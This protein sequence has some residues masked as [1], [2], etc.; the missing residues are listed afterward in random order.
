V[1][2]LIGNKTVNENVNLS[3][4]VSGADADG[5]ALTYSAT[6]LPSGATLNITS[7]VFSWSPSYSQSGSYSVVFTVS[8]GN[9]AT[10]SETI[11]ITVADMNRAPVLSAIGNKSA[12]ENTAL[13]FTISATD[14][15]NDTL[16]Y[17]AAGLPSGASLNS[18][19]GAF[20]WTPS[21]SQS[22]SYAVTFAVSD[23][24]VSDSEAITITVS[25]VN[26]APVLAA[27]G[28]KSVAENAALTFTV[29]ASDPDSDPVTLSASNLP[30]GASFNTSTGVFSWTPN[31]SQSETYSGVRFTASDGTLTDFEDITITVS[32]LNRAP[33][34]SAIGNKTVNENVNLSFTVSGA[35]ADGD[36]VTYSATGMP[37]GASFNTASG[38]FSWTPSYSQSGSYSV[39]FTVS[40]ENSATDSETIAITVADMNRAPVLSAIGIRQ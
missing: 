23:G 27:I 38:A 4:T 32:N 39:V 16:A 19:T 25:N 5:D 13:T 40:D 14:A 7:G 18:S 35:D 1:L 37:I 2:S 28:N 24:V 36:V 3:F 10:D 9:S 20:S 12:V 11:A 33:V 26:R 21:Y 17:S 29:T 6:G 31:Y 34:L 30:S 22:G 8:D 15:D